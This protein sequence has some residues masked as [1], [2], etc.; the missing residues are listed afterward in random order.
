MEEILFMTDFT[1]W[2]EY[3]NDMPIEDDYDYYLA[4]QEWSN[5]YRPHKFFV[6]LNP[7][8]QMYK[9]LPYGL[10]VMFSA[11]GFWDNDKQAWRRGKFK[12]FFGLRWLDCGGFTMLNQFDDYPFSVVNYANLVVRL[13]PHYYAT[14]D[15]PCEPEI[16]RAL[17]LLSNRER[18]GATV[19]NAVALAEYEK[20]L[21]GQMVPVIQGYTVDEYLEC[22]RLHVQAGTVR[23]YMAVGSMCR[24]I[25]DSELG[26]LIP[27]IYYAAQEAGCTKLHY[28]GLKLSSSV[29]LYADMIWSRDSA[30]VLT[31]YD[32]KLRTK[33]GRRFPNGQKEKEEVFHS[34][35]QRLERLGLN[36]VRG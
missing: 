1:D 28:F 33:W 24:R 8:W 11:Y 29:Q 22:L 36:F 9:F 31:S 4:R 35:L 18:I 15:Y 17:G 10:N 19:R 14:M 12:T 5:I 30:A 7:R 13:Q 2:L 16:S 20:E 26:N 25:S 23:D 34:F 21:P 3:E 6:G 32:A 27:A